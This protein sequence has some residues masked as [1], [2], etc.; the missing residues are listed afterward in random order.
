[1]KKKREKIEIIHSILE[2]IRDNRNYCKP[3]H[4]L[5]KSNLSYKM[6]KQYLNELI[7]K[8]FVTEEYDKKRKKS[9]SLTSKGFK[10]LEDYDIIK[11]FMESYGLN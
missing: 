8:G 3:T 6:L 4:I 5:Y 9:Y 10:F 2:T 7:D 11:S 1:M